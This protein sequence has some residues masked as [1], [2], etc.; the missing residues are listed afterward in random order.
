MS[1]HGYQ[2]LPGVH[3]VHRHVH[4]VGAD[5]DDVLTVV[6]NYDR[7]L[8][9]QI[10]TAHG[11]GTEGSTV[12]SETWGEVDLTHDEMVALRDRLDEVIAHRAAHEASLPT[13]QARYLSEEATGDHRLGVY[14]DNGRC[15]GVTTDVGGPRNSIRART[16]LEAAGY[17]IVGGPTGPDT[18]GYFA[19]VKEA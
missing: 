5:V 14:D 11:I 16:A 19:T 2:G 6:D 1:P 10:K 4:V 17:Q 18:F 15:Q 12:T 3:R 8:S 9:V 13:Y 7:T